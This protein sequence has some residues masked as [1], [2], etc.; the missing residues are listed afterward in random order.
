[1]EL[2][3]KLAELGATVICLDIDRSGNSKTEDRLKH[4]KAKYHMFCCDV[5]NKEDVDR[6]SNEILTNIGVPDLLINNAAIT[7]KKAFL[8]HSQE[9]IEDMFSIN[10]VGPMLLIRNFLPSMLKDPNHRH[11]IVGISSIVG[12]LGTP[13]MV[14]Y[15]ATKFAMTGFME[16]LNYELMADKGKNIV[17]TTVHP[18][19]VAS[20][21]NRKPS[22][23]Y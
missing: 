16:G 20:N 23:R 10:V 6:V 17:M 8:E 13:N 4:M 18:F 9:E 3:V 11:H 2:S 21:G 12:M 5:S 1:M 14:P 19:L 15:S 7:K 22:L